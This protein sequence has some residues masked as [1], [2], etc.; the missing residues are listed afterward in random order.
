MIVDANGV[1][2]RFHATFE[3][4]CEFRSA[5]LRGS[6]WIDLAGS[7]SPPPAPVLPTVTSPTTLFTATSD[8]GDVLGN[9]ASSSYTLANAVFIPRGY[10][11]QAEVSILPTS[12][13][14]IFFRIVA[15]AGNLG[16]G[17]YDSVPV[18]SSGS[19]SSVGGLGSCSAGITGKFTI[20]EYSQGPN[21]DLYAFRMGIELR[22]GTAT[23]AYRV[24]IN[25]FADP[26]R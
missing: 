23:A 8:P 24:Q 19:G 13:G 7:T 15:P 22:C 20:L 16:V 11:S 3:Q 9:G 5:A 10:D 2:Q 26:W 14:S 4:H 17:T 12:G 18:T 1:L 21:G 6:I 25:V